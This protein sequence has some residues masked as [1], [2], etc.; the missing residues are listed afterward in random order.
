MSSR[1]PLLFTILLFFLDFSPALGYPTLIRRRNR[2][3]G[4]RGN[5]TALIFVDNSYKNMLS[6]FV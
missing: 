5:W 6:M 2:R 3:G 1:V 4:A